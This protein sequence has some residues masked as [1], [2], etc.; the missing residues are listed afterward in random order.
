[1][2]KTYIIPELDVIEIR[3]TSMLTASLG[4]DS[5]PVNPSSSDAPDFEPD[6]NM[7]GY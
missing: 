3:M 1:M 5:T 6:P 4:T 7:F 2:K